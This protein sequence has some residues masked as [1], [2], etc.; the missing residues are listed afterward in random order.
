MVLV[1]QGLKKT[2]REFQ[3]QPKSFRHDSEFYQNFSL[4]NYLK[5]KISLNGFLLGIFIILVCTLNIINTRFFAGT[6]PWLHISIVKYITVVNHIPMEEYYGAIGLHIF[7]A[8]IHFF[9]GLDLLLLPKYYLFYTIPVSSLI[10]YNLLMRIFKNKNLAIFGVYLLVSSFGFSFFMMV[11]FW[12]SGIAL[13]QGLIIFFILYVRLQAFIKQQTPKNTDILS[14]MTSTYLLLTIIFISLILTHSLIAMI[15]LISYLWIYLIYF[16]KNFRRGFDFLLLMFF[17]CI[18]FLFYY[19]NIATGYFQVFNPFR[20]LS[21]YYLLFGAFVLIFIATFLLRYYLKSLNFKNKIFNLIIIG[22]EKRIYKKMEDKYIFPLIFG[23]GLILTIIFSYFNLT[24]FKIHISYIFFFIDSLI[25][26]SFA[27]WGLVI[28]QYKPRGKPLFFWGIALDFLLLVMFLIDAMIGMTTFF[29]R[30]FYLTL[31]IMIIGFVSYL[32]KIIKLNSF[33]NRK[34]KLFLIF[35]VIFSIYTSYLFDSTSKNIFFL[36][37]QEVKSIQWYS[38]YT[39]KEQVIISKFGWYAIFIYFDYPFEDKNRDLELEAINYFLTLDDQYIHPS[40]HISEGIN[41]LKE[42]KST[43]NT[44]V[45]L[46]LPKEYYLP[47]NWQFFDRLSYEE[48]EAYYHLDYLNRIFS[49]KG[50]N[51]EETPYYWVI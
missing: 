34:F 19:F 42:L 32:Y 23:M 50:E 22:K 14:N 2:Y 27:I 4:L 39:S 29:L 38:N 51:D 40:L 30:V 18:F 6:D 26:A 9:S 46:I 45:I 37:E 10:I 33:Q 47:F 43:Y 20:I 15:L 5:K 35:F 25:L 11:Q 24:I 12:P 7:G 41:I 28:F 3:S 44:D 16:V 48:I 1:I 31:I 17:F 8:V 36:R 21:W 13:I 49:A